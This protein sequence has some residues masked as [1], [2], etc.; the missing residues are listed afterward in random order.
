[1]SKPAFVEPMKALLVDKLPQGPG[2]IYEIKFDGV[3][4]LAIKDEA[5]VSLI[6]RAGKDIASK[7]TQVVEAVRSVPAGKFV[8]DGEIAAVDSLGCSSFQLLQ[9]YNALEGKPP[10]LSQG[11]GP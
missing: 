8:L 4:A 2:W 10:P 3:R 6:S 7:Y 5:H 11:K 1:L 9:S